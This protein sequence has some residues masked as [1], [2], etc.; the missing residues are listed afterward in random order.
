M[1]LERLSRDY[2]DYRESIVTI[3]RFQRLQ[4]EYC[5]YREIIE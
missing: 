1:I 3:V 2:S 5:D 4:G